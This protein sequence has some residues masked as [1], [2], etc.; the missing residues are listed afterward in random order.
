MILNRNTVFLAEQDLL[1]P[2]VRAALAALARDR[3]KVFTKTE[4][5]GAPVRLAADPACRAEAYTL[6]AG[7]GALILTAGDDLGVVYGLYEISRR[8]GGGLFICERPVQGALARL[9]FER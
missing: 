6:A 2:P 1:T 4:A 3:D 9:V 8:G 5:P 7:G